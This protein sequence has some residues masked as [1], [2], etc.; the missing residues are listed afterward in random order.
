MRSL[1]GI[2]G[3][4]P[5]SFHPNAKDVHFC[6]G[7]V[8]PLV[9]TPGLGCKRRRAIARRF[10]DDA[11][12]FCQMGAGAC[13]HVVHQVLLLAFTPKVLVFTPRG[14]AFTPQGFVFTPQGLAFTPQ[15]LL[16]GGAH[17]FVRPPHIAHM[18]HITQIQHITQLLHIEGEILGEITWRDIG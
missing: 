2:L 16:Q 17:V 1:G 14:L 18:L 9:P 6:G 13:W 3:E 7:R 11:T 15:G 5:C 12:I 4:I 10:N 8:D